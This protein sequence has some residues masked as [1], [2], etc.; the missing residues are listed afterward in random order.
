MLNKIT[1]QNLMTDQL[2]HKQNLS[3]L[4]TQTNDKI[5]KCDITES[6]CRSFAEF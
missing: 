4:S 5:D 3:P 6:R 2:N 1:T